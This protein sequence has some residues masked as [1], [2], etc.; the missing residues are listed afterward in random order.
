LVVLCE[1]SLLGRQLTLLKRVGRERVV[2]VIEARARVRALAFAT[3]SCAKSIKLSGELGL[4]LDERAAVIAHG[5][6]SGIG[7]L[8]EQ[9]ETGRNK[10]HEKENQGKDGVV[11]EEDDTHDSGYDTLDELTRS[12]R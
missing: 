10:D 1:A 3:G 8:R 6:V 5:L 7:V 12:R 11:Y 2:V 9:G 4:R